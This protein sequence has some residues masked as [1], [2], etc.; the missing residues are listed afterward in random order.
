MKLSELSLSSLDPAFDKISKLTRSQRITISVATFAVLAG[1]F[2]YFSY[3]PLFTQ[4]DAQSQQLQQI[5]KQ[6]AD[7]RDVT[8]HINKYRQDMKDAEGEFMLTRNALPEKE[9][10]PLLLRT[11]SQFGHDVGLDFLLFEPKEEIVKDFYAELPVS[12]HVIGNYH[13]A[14]MFFDKISNLNRVVNI[15]DIK[16]AP[17]KDNTRGKQPNAKSAPSID[18]HELTTTCTAVTYKFIENPV[19][20]AAPQVQKKKP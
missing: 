2:G 14:V 9:E 11:I 10:V 19:V 18:R 4:L 8:K 12:I 7:A 5:D 15:R 13:N 20:P 17:S 6:L 3:Y 16:M 1:L